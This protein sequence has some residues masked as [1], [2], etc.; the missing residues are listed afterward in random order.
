[1]K[2][3]WVK[4]KFPSLVA[5]NKTADRSPAT[6]VTWGPDHIL[7]T[8]LY[9]KMSLYHW[10]LN[11]PHEPPHIACTCKYVSNA[12]WSA[13]SVHLLALCMIYTGATTINQTQTERSVSL[14]RHGPSTGQLID[15]VTSK[16][17]KP[18]ATSRDPSRDRLSTRRRNPLQ[19]AT[20]RSAYLQPIATVMS[21]VMWYTTQKELSHSRS[22]CPADQS[23]RRR[24][25]RLANEPW[26]DLLHVRAISE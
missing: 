18:R 14:P 13:V 21:S 16:T 8:H 20:S 22:R 6:A 11:L 26:A 25:V 7:F 5:I 24:Y 10:C 15:E 12:T 4:I 3:K 2:H 1:M 23:E 17:I 19:I 9:K